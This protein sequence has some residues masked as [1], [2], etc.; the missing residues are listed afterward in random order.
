MTTLTHIPYKIVHQIFSFHSKDDF[1]K[2]HDPSNQNKNFIWS[3]QM[4]LVNQTFK[5]CFEHYVAQLFEW[6]IKK[7]KFYKTFN[8]ENGDWFEHVQ[9]LNSQFISSIK[10]KNTKSN[11]SKNRNI[12]KKIMDYVF[13]ITTSSKI[14][15]I[16]FKPQYIELIQNQTNHLCIM[17]LEKNVD[18]LQYIRNQTTELCLFAV[19]C[20]AKALKWVNQQTENICI[21]AVKRNPHLI[22]QVKQKTLNVCLAAVKKNGNALKHIEQQTEEICLEAVKQNG[23]SLRYVKKQTPFICLEAVKQN[24]LSIKYVKDLSSDICLEAL[25]QSARSFKHAV[26]PYWLRVYQKEYI[27]LDSVLHIVQTKYVSKNKK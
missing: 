4:R 9:Y 13:P 6:N 18:A 21:E 10:Q 12:T 11:P 8:V 16:K 3:I 24:G 5:L 27:C 7:F 22:H 20:D 15:L 25:K 26:E 19:K 2:Y 14:E 23:L 1:Q 17:S